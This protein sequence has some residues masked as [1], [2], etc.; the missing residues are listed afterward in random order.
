MCN[1]VPVGLIGRQLAVIHKMTCAAAAFLSNI[2][3][4]IIL[5]RHL[6]HTESFIISVAFKILHEGSIHSLMCL[7]QIF[8][9]C[10]LLL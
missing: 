3:I 10:A 5:K 6:D 1:D 4:Y 2:E 7:F 9:L 8:S